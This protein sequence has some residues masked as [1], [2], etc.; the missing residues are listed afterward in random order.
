M[1]EMPQCYQHGGHVCTTTKAVFEQDLQGTSLKS[2]HH[3]SP[4]PP[5]KGDSK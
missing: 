1:S 4:G 2:K 5:Y 3:P